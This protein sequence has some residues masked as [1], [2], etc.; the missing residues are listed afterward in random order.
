SGHVPGGEAMTNGFAALR[1]GQAI[2]RQQ[3]PRLA[4]S[5]FRRTILDEVA[6]GLRVAALFGDE[7]AGK[8]NIYCVLADN[9]RSRLHAGITTLESDGLES[10]TP[11]CP[12]L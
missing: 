4:V 7:S 2:A 12:Q 5:D 10:L 11:E 9:A 6:D 8:V 1:S 3:I